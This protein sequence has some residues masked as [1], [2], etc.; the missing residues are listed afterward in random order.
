[1]TSKREYCLEVKKYKKYKKKKKKKKKKKRQAQF[2][3]IMLQLAW[4]AEQ[5]HWASITLYSLG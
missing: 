1:L 3:Y 2:I 5:K 4:K